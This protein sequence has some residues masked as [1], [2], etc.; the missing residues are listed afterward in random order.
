MDTVDASVY[1]ATTR[2][3]RQALP[4]T[5]LQ[6]EL[7]AKMKERKKLGLTADITSEESEGLDSEEENSNLLFYSIILF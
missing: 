3:Q 2:K 5:S 7:Q 4:K 1:Q 6:Q